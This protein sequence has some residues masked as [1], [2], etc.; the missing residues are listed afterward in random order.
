MRS[1]VLSVATLVLG[2]TAFTGSASANTTAAQCEAMLG[3]VAGARE[4][5]ASLEQSLVDVD[6]ERVELVAAIASVEK[7]IAKAKGHAM[8]SLRAELDGLTVELNLVDELRPELVRQI[9]G[10]RT[11]IDATERGYISCIE[12]VI[13]G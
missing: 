2:L 13:A 4:A 1:I 3:D 11:D 5:L 12:T 6:A 8:L 10:L 9:E 7:K